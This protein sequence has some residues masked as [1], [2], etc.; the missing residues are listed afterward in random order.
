[1]AET[2]IVSTKE[3]NKYYPFVGLFHLVRNSFYTAGQDSYTQPPA[4][5]PDMFELLTNVEPVTRGILERRR[6]YT[7]F[8]SQTPANPFQRSYSYLNDSLS[9]RKYI[10][11][12]GTQV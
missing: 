6:G 3:E 10:W 11:C 8:S 12:R 9:L 4:Q 2:R 1:M 5:N 7:L